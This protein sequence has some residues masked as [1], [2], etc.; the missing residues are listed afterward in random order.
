MAKSESPGAGRTAR[1]AQ[2]NAQ[3]SCSDNR[4]YNSPAIA[5]QQPELA[6]AP[7][8]SE[9]E[10][11][12]A[13]VTRER[14]R[15][16]YVAQ[17]AS[18]MRWT[19]RSWEHDSTLSIFDAIRQLC[20]QRARGRGKS[21]AKRIC[22][23]HTVAAVEGLAR[24]DQR[25]AATPEQW[26]VDAWLLNTPA[27]VVDL[28]SG[29]LRDHTPTDYMS[30]ST[31]VS[32][33]PGSRCPIWH[34]FLDRISGKDKAF[35]DYLQRVF[36]Y[37]LT[38]STREQVLFFLHGAG[39]NGKSIVVKTVTSIMGN[40]AKVAPD[41]IFSEMPGAQHPTDLAG[42]RGAR[43]ATATETEQGR[44]WNEARIKLLTGGD[45]VTARQ[46]RRDFFEFTPQFKLMLAGNH[47]PSLR[48]VD[49]ANRRRI[50]LLPFIVT[51]PEEERD[52]QLFERLK[53]EWPGILA[54]MIEGCVEWQRIGLAPPATVRDASATYMDA[55][56]TLAAWIDECCE[57]VLAAW[58]STRDLYGS[59][60]DF[61]TSRGEHTESMKRFVQKLEGFGFR[62][63][64]KNSARGF[65]GLRLRAPEA[66]SATLALVG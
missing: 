19:G 32:P 1:G 54:W 10:L 51:I 41:S 21:D 14:E 65:L 2:G 56:N 18:W 28:R 42:L 63:L 36:G 53:S 62:P 46:M 38:G 24:V 5:K 60:Q 27:S 22:S 30:K 3:L 52:P 45:T 50:Q 9:D 47:K 13:F 58:E 25:I 39:A 59:W 40:Y 8:H 29:L 4:N 16:R 7:P 43:L 35:K 33:E 12:T 61:A 6:P 55:E 64:R 66:K 17:W 15:L 23:K 37:V 48:S 49:E 20:R 44:N 31:A 26:D 57:R 34:G 11:A